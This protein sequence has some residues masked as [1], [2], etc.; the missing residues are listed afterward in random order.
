[1]TPLDWDPTRP[2][3]RELHAVP[4]QLAQTRLGTPAD[5]NAIDSVLAAR[6]AGAP[7]AQ[8]DAAADAVLAAYTKVLPSAVLAHRDAVAKTGFGR[9]QVFARQAGRLEAKSWIALRDAMAKAMH[10][11]LAA[12]YAAVDADA[13]AGTRALATALAVPSAMLEPEWSQPPVARPGKPIPSANGPASVLVVPPGN[14]RAGVAVMRHE[15]SRADYASFANSTGRA[16][17]RCRN[18]L[19]PISIKRRSWASPGFAQTG[20]HP[21]VCVSYEDARAY[22]S[23]L[24]QRTG[25]TWRLPSASE[26]KLFAGYRGTGSACNDG[27][28]DCGQDGTI[29]AGLGPQS[30]LGLTGVRGNAREW[31]ND[32]V[33][34]CRQ[35]LVG[36]LGWRDNAARAEPLRSSGFDSKSGFDDVG[37]RLVRDVGPR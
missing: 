9:A 20:D 14:N 36:G 30:P 24:S 37:F 12:G 21:A 7:A 5:D 25:E 27:R 2:G 34:T 33:G 1:V 4:R 31:L 15:V 32:C 35:H 18:R 22:A 11:R 10:R 29:G 19:A 16:S 6:T 17:A 3:A 26:W 28:V 8:V 13:V 23:W